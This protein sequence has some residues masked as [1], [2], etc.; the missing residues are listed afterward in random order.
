VRNIT[1]LHPDVLRD[2]EKSEPPSLYALNDQAL[3]RGRQWQINLLCARRTIPGPFARIDDPP[4]IAPLL[5]QPIIELCVRIPTWFQMEDRRD[6]ALSRAALEHDLPPEIHAR[7]DKGEAEDFAFAIVQQNF[8]FLREALL[9][10]VIATSG[11]IDRAR[12]AA[13][14]S[15]RPSAEAVTSVPLFDLLGAEIWARAWQSASAHA[16]QNAM[17]SDSR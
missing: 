3:S 6:R 16:D 14:L 8:E 2:L 13:V 9:D 17:P 1:L 4:Q 15:P 11:L 12:L 10:G 7:R 5:S